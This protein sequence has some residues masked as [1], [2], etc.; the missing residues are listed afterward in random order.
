[1]T[2][3]VMDTAL[4]LQAMAGP[5]PTDPWSIGTTP[6][7]YIA[8]ARPEGDLK[9]KRILLQRHARQPLRVEGRDDRLRGARSAS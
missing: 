8:A 6:Q 4:M 9:G 7:D 3:T 2:R 1:M 5:H